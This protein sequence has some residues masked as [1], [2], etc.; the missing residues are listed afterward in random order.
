[1]QSN[2]ALAYFNADRRGGLFDHVGPIFWVVACGIAMIISVVV[3]TAATISSFRE[4]EVERAEQTLGS[5]AKL[6]A[7]HF[8]RQMTDFE[9]V[10]RAVASHIAMTTKSDQEFMTYTRNQSFHELL[11]NKITD[12]GDAAGV[13]VFDADGD[14]AA[15]SNEWPVKSR[16][17]ADRKY[18]QTFKNDSSSP[19]LLVEL[20]DSK[21]A[22]GQVIVL[23][24]KLVGPSGQFWGMVTRSIHPEALESFMS[25]VA[26]PYVSI[27]LLHQDGTL[28]ARVPHVRGAIGQN[29]AESIES[30]ES[31]TKPGSSDLISPI[32][33][34]RRLV[35]MRRLAQYPLTIVATQE[36]E[37]ALSNWQQQSRLIGWGM[38][39]VCTAGIFMLGLIVRS[40]KKQKR[41]LD[42]AV[43][44][45]AQGLLLHDSHGRLML[46]NDRY[47]QLFNIPSD[48]AQ[49]GTGLR[50][51]ILQRKEHGAVLSDVD[52]HCVTI[53]GAVSRNERS[54]LI[55]KTQEG[56]VIQL[57]SQ[58]LME[59]GWISTFD[60]IT[61][62]L[63]SEERV[64][65]LAYLDCLTDLPNRMHFLHHLGS[66]LEQHRNL[67]LLFIDT[68]EFKAVNDCLGHLLGDE[69]LRSIANRLKN[70]LGPE[71]FLARLGGDEFAIILQSASSPAD[72]QAFIDQ[73]Y[74]LL[75]S[76]HQCGP[77]TLN[78]NASIGVAFAPR[79]GRTCEELLQNADLA[80]YA[81]KAAGRGTFRFFEPEMERLVRERRSLEDDL[82]GAIASEG[83][84]VY[85]QPILGLRTNE[86]V[87]CE[88]LARWNHPTRGQVS[89]ADFVSL[90]EQAGLIDRL[91][92]HVLQ[93]A[94]REAA[95]WPVHLRI[96]VNISPLQLKGG[97]LPLKLASILAESGLQAN[98]LELE[99]T[100][101]VL[102][103]DDD[104][105][106]KVLIE[107]KSLGVRIALDD[108][109]TGYSSLSYL[110]K[111]PFDKIKIDRSFINQLESEAKSAGIIRAVVALAAEHEISTTAEGVETERQREILAELNCDEMQGY[112]FS[113]ARPTN[114]I[115][116]MLVCDQTE[117]LVG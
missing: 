4:R 95:T 114:L 22:D 86:I 34:K 51:L 64:R 36:R 90:A 24:R 18:F 105:A 71:D 41:T 92:E 78:A 84:E 10:E 117:K 15:S 93:E 66:Q 110:S 81:A 5:T 96:A 101:A 32:D 49:P 102:I 7:Y 57:T 33:G 65:R 27:A 59:G 87:G 48:L 2:T 88:A 21:I 108:F 17:L 35:S 80:M 31:G 6:L 76:P 50:E 28:L 29:F 42:V 111:F 52:T 115:R 25:S 39:A 109:G 8:D 53:L 79:H 26:V 38:A 30:V 12:S 3:G 104:A 69:L 72:V 9:A 83:I 107:I 106:L 19:A 63:R 1:M 77:H 89:P 67:T 91:G 46:R 55:E 100:E 37:S 97:T 116:K 113:A 60:D 13:N 68:D 73:L 40:L 85:Y 11:R 14:W 75:R 70:C 44:N 45:M 20:V 47:L 103:G 23:A 98:R 56:R 43:N 54:G 62:R 74:A 112:L 16:N 99:I 82:R 61:D 58:P 94:C